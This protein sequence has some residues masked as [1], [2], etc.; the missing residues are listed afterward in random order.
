MIPRSAVA[1]LSWDH[2]RWQGAVSRSRRL[3]IPCWLW[4]L[5]CN[6]ASALEFGKSNNVLSGQV[7]VAFVGQPGSSS[8]RQAT[9]LL[10]AR[11]SAV[12]GEE[13]PHHPEKRIHREKVNR[14]HEF[15]LQPF[16][17]ILNIRG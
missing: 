3:F 15:V 9:L 16:T 8:G 7:L 12:W 4:L 5:L 1:V 17:L 2:D 13:D 6:R 10:A 11:V 14:S